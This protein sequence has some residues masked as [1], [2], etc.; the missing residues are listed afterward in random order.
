MKRREVIAMLS[1][2]AA[3]AAWPLATRAQQ[4]SVSSEKA[5]TDSE[6]ARGMA[7]KASSIG[8]YSEWDHL[9]EVLV[10][11]NARDTV[12]RW[13]PDWGRYHGFK[14]MLKGLEGVRASQA[15]PDRTKGANEQTDA[16]AKVLQDHGVVVHRPRLLTDTEIASEPVAG[17]SPSTPAIRRSSSAST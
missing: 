10:G 9:K 14:E 17:S 12:P 7:T 11:N 4:P 15:F 3:T 5:A 6:R 8:V 13:S 16:L 1:S 2:A